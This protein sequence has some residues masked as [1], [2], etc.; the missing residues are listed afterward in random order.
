MS[1]KI[2]KLYR[3]KNQRVIA[4]VCGGFAEYIETDPTVIRL[5]FILILIVTGILP[6]I[7]F[8]IISAIIIPEK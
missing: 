5:I 3:S 2:K 1:R 7:I 4:G 8:Y 6:G